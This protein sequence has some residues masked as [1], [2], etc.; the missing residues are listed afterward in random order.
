M[1]TVT[2]KAVAAKSVFADAAVNMQNI[3]NVNAEKLTSAQNDDEKREFEQARK[4]AETHEKFNAAL[5]DMS[6]KALASLSRYNVDAQV[7]SEQSRE[8]KKRSIAILEAVANNKR[9]DDTALDAM[10]QRLAAKKDATMTLA[11]IQREMNH[12]TT[13]QAQYFKTCAQFFNFAQYSKSDKALT[14]NYDS[15]VLKDLLK[16]YASA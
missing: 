16:Q 2:D 15:K 3:K 8:L 9:V 13:T 4:R 10:L 11:Q 14:F 12:K 6:E 5:S 1:N 7:L